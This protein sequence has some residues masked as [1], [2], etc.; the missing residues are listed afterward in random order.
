MTY[1]DVN[2]LK[3][4]FKNLLDVQKDL[5]IEKISTTFTE[6]DLKE[7]VFALGYLVAVMAKQEV[8]EL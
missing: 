1:S 3:M 6:Y 5:Q 8:T 4:R 7:I 2:R